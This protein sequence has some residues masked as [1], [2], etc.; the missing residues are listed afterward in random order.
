MTEVSNAVL[1]DALRRTRAMREKATE[2]LVERVAPDG[3][4]IGAERLNGYYRLPWALG[5]NGERELASRV[6]SWIDEN[7]LDDRGD[8]VPGAARLPFEHQAN[9]S[10]PLSQIAIGAWHLEQYDIAHRVMKGLLS[11]FQSELTGGVFSERPSARGVDAHQDVLVSAQF[12]M[13]CITAGYREAA[14]RVA[15]WFARLLEA[16]PELPHALYTSWTNEGLVTEYDDTT[17]WNTVVFFDR[18]YQAFYMP[19]IAAAFLGRHYQTTGSE[20]SLVLADRFVELSAAGEELQWKWQE[21]SQICKWAW[22]TAVLLD[23]APNNRYA[24]YTLRMVDWFE[25]SQ[26]D[27]GRW[28]PSPFLNSDPDDA[29]D[30]PKVAEH[31][32]HLTTMETAL[33]QYDTARRM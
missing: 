3:R 19:G 7:V 10:Y 23:A 32:L 5:I 6:L 12:G 11:D 27:D 30:M 9:A 24:E 17:A 2:W 15:D 4:P 31:L 28:H 26:E 21:N 18:P 33:A 25:E 29:D 8:L 13:A 1:R 20:R 14:D 22:G 16:Q